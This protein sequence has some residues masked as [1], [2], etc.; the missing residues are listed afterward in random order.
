MGGKLE[1]QR[2]LSP[3]TLTLSVVFYGPCSKTPWWWRLCRPRWSHV[4]LRIED[5]VWDQPFVGVGATY[6][7]DD[8]CADKYEAGRRI[9]YVVL[10]VGDDT[11]LRSMFSAFRQ[12]EHRRSQPILSVL[13]FLKL[14][15]RPVWNCTSPVRLVLH[16]L[17]IPV[18]GETP[19]VLASELNRMADDSEVLATRIG[20]VG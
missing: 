6:R 20:L 11:D 17:G 18:T 9:A 14:W 3:L 13:R 1:S 19:D 12:I 4:S 16:S 7:Y 2:N 5:R 8:F 15:P 10:T